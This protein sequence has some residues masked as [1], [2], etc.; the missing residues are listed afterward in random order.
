MLCRGR[1]AEY[2]H[3]MRGGVLAGVLCAA[4]ACSGQ[5]YEQAATDLVGEEP[6]PRHVVTFVGTEEG[7][8]EPRPELSKHQTSPAPTTAELAANLGVRL[9]VKPGP[10]GDVDPAILAEVQ[11]R[12]GRGVLRCYADLRKRTPAAGNVAVELSIDPRGHVSDASVSG[13]DPELDACIRPRV[14]AWR[15]PPAAPSTGK[16]TPRTLRLQLVLAPR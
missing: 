12:Y 11:A 9:D 6:V 4:F 3:S 13:F 7:A 14:R 2:R 8:P 1:A 16:P 10:G 5:G 15:F